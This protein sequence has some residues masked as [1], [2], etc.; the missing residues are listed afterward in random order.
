MPKH[1]DTYKMFALAKNICNY[2]FRKGKLEL[3]KKYSWV[4]DQPDVG[5]IN[6]HTSIKPTEARRINIATSGR[7]P[8]RH[9]MVCIVL[10][11]L[12]IVAL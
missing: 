3:Q 10:N 1:H 7:N 12:L 6:M 11:R 5:P 9:I 4:S 2:V 8:A